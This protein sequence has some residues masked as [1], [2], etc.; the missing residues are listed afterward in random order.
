[1]PEINLIAE[2]V[3][4]SLPPPPKGEPEH[5]LLIIFQELNIDCAIP[6]Q[7]PL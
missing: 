4:K 3:K 1:M 6:S 7:V 5:G 2:I